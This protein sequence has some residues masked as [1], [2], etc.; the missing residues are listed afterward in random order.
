M[1]HSELP[2]D[3]IDYRALSYAI[4]I[5]RYTNLQF[6]YAECALNNLSIVML[7]DLFLTGGVFSK[8]HA[9][10]AEDQ[11]SFCATTASIT[12]SHMTQQSCCNSA[13]EVVASQQYTL[14]VSYTSPRY[15]TGSINFF[16]NLSDLGAVFP[17]NSLVLQSC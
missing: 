4:H 2:I 13:E 5:L 9:H 15:G 3:R 8:Q 1:L 10:I 16:R 7:S 6:I 17:I 12:L 14:K 11:L